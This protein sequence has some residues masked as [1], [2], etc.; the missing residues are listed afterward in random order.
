MGRT[1]SS[2]PTNVYWGSA[3]DVEDAVSYDA[4]MKRRAQRP[5]SQPAGLLW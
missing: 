3:R 4:A 1:E 5:F 2:A